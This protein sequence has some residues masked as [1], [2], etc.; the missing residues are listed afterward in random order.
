MEHLEDKTLLAEEFPY[1]EFF[2]NSRTFGASKKNKFIPWFGHVY[3]YNGQVWMWRC[4]W[5]LA[6]RDFL[7]SQSVQL[8]WFISGMKHTIKWVEST[9]FD[10]PV[11]GRS[12]WFGLWFVEQKE[13]GVLERTVLFLLS[14]LFWL[15]TYCDKLAYKYLK[16]LLQV[17]RCF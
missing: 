13:N 7:E 9:L 4:L 11:R 1:N 8:Y 12:E 14:S 15:C 2:K 3:F 10:T 16:A 17:T 6:L 5:D